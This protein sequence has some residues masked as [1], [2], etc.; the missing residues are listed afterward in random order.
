MP[1][2][3]GARHDAHEAQ[4]HQ[5]QRPP[6]KLGGEHADGDHCQDMIDPGD[7]MGEALQQSIRVAVS[8]MGKRNGRS[9]D[10]N[11]AERREDCASHELLLGGAGFITSRPAG[12]SGE[13]PGIVQVT[14]ARHQ[15]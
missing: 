3:A 15:H 6:A 10:E 12:C 4:G 11:G 14:G 8:G 13:W 5:P 9:K 1:R 2:S 7:R